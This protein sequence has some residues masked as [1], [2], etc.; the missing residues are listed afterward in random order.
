MGSKNIKEFI[1]TFTPSNIKRLQYM[2]QDIKVLLEDEFD[3]NFEKESFFTTPWE[4]SQRAKNTGGKTLQD[5]THLRKSIHAYINGSKIVFESNKNYAAIH[6]FGGTIH[7]K[8]RVTPKMR[9]WAWA[10]YKETKQDK[11]KGLAL[12]KKTRL[13]IKA[14]M[15]PRQFI[16]WHPSLKP[17]IDRVITKAIND[18]F[19]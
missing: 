5:R 14:T 11:Y 6:N 2:Q 1:R 15:P 13:S 4:P 10:K 17:K 16:G 12:T 8:P 3:N 18:I 7:S 9:R 19:K